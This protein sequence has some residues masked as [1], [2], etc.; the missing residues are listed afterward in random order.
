MTRRS[1]RSSAPRLLLGL[2]VGLSVHGLEDRLHAQQA[3]WTPMSELPGVEAMRDLGRSA[4]R[5][6]GGGRVRDVRFDDTHAY[7]LSPEGWRKVALEGGEVSEADATALPSRPRGDAR[8]GNRGPRPA[9]GRQLTESPSPD[10]AWT[11]VHEDHNVVLRAEDGTELPVTTDGTEAFRYGTASW[12]YG[13]ELDQTDAMWWSPDGR[14]L[15]FYAFDVSPTRD[16]YLVDGLSSLRS[17]IKRERYPK[18]GDPNPIAGLRIFECDTGELVEVDIGDDPDQYVYAVRWTPDG[19][20]LL[21]NRT[22]RHQNHLEVMAADPGTGESRLVVEERQDT[23]Q[24]NRPQMR[25]LDDGRRFL[26]ETEK[27]G[28]KQLELRDLD[29]TLVNALTGTDPRFADAPVESIVKLDEDAGMLWYTMRSSETPINNQLHRV[30][31]D[32]TDERRITT[33][34]L[35]HGSFRISDDGRMIA[36]TREAVDHA[37]ETVIHAE[38]GRE[39]AVIA[40]GDASGLETT[41]LAGGELVRFTAADGTTPLHA[42]LHLPANADRDAIARYPLLVDVYGG[43]ESRGPSNTWS[44]ANAACELGFAVAKI[45]NRG[46]IGRG[47]A[48]EGATYLRLGGP[49]LDDQVA[50]VKAILEAHPEIDPARVGIAGHSYGG[51]L[52][53]LALVRH[54][55]VFRAGVAG[56]PVTD[57]RNYDTIYTER[58][59]R[60]PQ[61][62]PEGYD[63]G[64]AVKLA[65]R[66]EG[67][68]LLLHGMQDDNVHPANTFQ[69]ARRLQDADIPFEMQIFPDAGHGIPSAAYR[70]S[71]WSFL[72]EHLGAAET[73]GSPR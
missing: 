73:A 57:F 49:D 24:R 6:G 62:N 18:A 69:M 43:P 45:E 71:K 29:G 11:A 70:S 10:G 9:R 30:R 48:F 8:R 60:T 64:S 26:W 37:P 61:E 5:I 59:M 63:A 32:G 56:A 28:W 46:T 13:E 20:E 53:A 21:F 23:W 25:F 31:L 54:P 58:Y 27:S 14:H 15:A 38:D 40:R 16:Y 50:G 52:A 51:Y 65:N 41:G 72:Q 66:L 35:N 3:G 22:N 33:A 67:A 55:D 47:K 2:V 44:P 12:V 68:L 36:A 7:W 1:I 39:I 42:V 17:E 4:R 19:G 34:D